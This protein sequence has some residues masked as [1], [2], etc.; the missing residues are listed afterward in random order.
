VRNV[1]DEIPSN[2]GA[3]TNRGPN[4][5]KEFYDTHTTL[6]N[7][8]ILV[9]CIVLALILGMGSY[10]I[11][12]NINSILRALGNTIL[13]S[14]IAIAMGFALGI[15][16]GLGRV[17][18][19]IFISGICS[20]Y[21]NILR[22]TPLLIQIFFIYFG[23]PAVGFLIDPIVAAV[24]ALGLNSG[25]YQ[26]EIIRGGI[27]SI[28]KG[29]MEA[30]RSTGMSYLKAMRYIIIPQGLRLIIP[31]M[32]NEYVTVIKD[33]SLAYAIG[34]FELTYIGYKLESWYF[35]PFI[36]F[37]FIALLYF[38]LTSITSS[39]MMYVENRTRIPGYMG[40]AE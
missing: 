29:Q 5:V 7:K 12:G 2:H 37:T 19:N 32:T 27:Q 26:G 3:R 39:I 14:V 28:P 25:A 38:I 4:Q 9:V 6:V 35:Q 17:S 30:A 1:K 20:I 23:L 16:I 40:G 21:V 18:R 22:G 34:V 15:V 13:I 11:N 10:I 36:V 8:S 31:P 33:S 24:L